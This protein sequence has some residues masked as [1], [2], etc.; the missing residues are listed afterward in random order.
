MP[1]IL[2]SNTKLFTT[3]AALAR[4][5]TE[6]TLGTEVLGAGRARR[7]RRLARRP[8]PARRRRPH[9]RHA[10]LRATAS[11][12]GGRHGRGAGRAGRAGRHRARD[13]PGL[14]GRVALR[15]PARRPRL[16][17]RRLDLGR[18]AERASP[19]TAGSRPRRGS[20]FQSSPPAFAAARLDAALEARGI[21][22]RLKPRARAAPA[23]TPRARERRVA[24]DGAAGA[25]HEQAV[26]QL[27]RRDAAQGPGACRRAAVG[28]TKAGARAGGR[29]RAPARRPR[30]ARRRLGPLA[31]QPRLA[32]P[33]GAAA[34]R[35]DAAA[36]STTPSS[37]RCRSPAATARS[38][39]GC[40]A[41]PP[42]PLP[43]QDRHAL[44]RERAVRLLRGRSRRHLRLLDPDERRLPERRPR[45]PGPDAPGDRRAAPS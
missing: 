26:R 43:R 22:V 36:R 14:R 3:A 12:G 29:L 21:R 4:F 2:A 28:T 23:G 10:P 34:H 13:R 20:G 1:R 41:A 27:L 33:R 11:Y 40:G 35:D 31:R 7:G 5:G 24:A 17:L 30:A 32:L 19:S 9:L 39:T 42:A 44:G 18:P 25:A 45:A 16:R 6:G 8:V 38:R 15:L 37:T